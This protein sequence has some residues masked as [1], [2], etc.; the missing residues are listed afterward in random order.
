M[1]KRIKKEEIIFAVTLSA[2]PVF[3]VV[4]LS[5]AVMLISG[6]INPIAQT[7]IVLISS[8]VIIPYLM[9]KHR[10]DISLNDLGF[11]AKDKMIM[12]IEGII[13]TTFVL[14]V[15]IVVS[16]PGALSLV[17]TTL[18]VAV[19]EEFWA[20]GCLFYIY[21]RIFE[22]KFVVM[23]VST[24]VFVFVVHMNRGVTENFFYR[25]PG[26]LIM[27]LIYWKSG[28]LQYSVGFHFIYNILG[29]I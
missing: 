16:P 28:K 5:I 2:L 29:S 23:L 10:F 9:M 15:K 3:M 12:I 11:Y 24:L 4:V 19:S 26:G 22:N 14:I 1:I 7:S 27:G 6:D 13:I 21:G 20:R 8:F 18:V 17:L 25:L